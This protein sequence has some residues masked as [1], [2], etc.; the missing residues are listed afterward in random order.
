MRLPRLSSEIARLLALVSPRCGIVRDVVA[1]A[2]SVDEPIP[3][4]LYH[5][6]LS[7]FD[8]KKGNATDRA[9]AGKGLTEAEAIGGAIGEAVERY[10]ASHVDS[11]KLR[12]ARIME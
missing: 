9:A 2:R 10:C 1:V 5:A 3:P 11:K 6:T 4:I 8:F 7:N 12:R